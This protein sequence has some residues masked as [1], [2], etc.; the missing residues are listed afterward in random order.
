MADNRLSS[1]PVSGEP[2]E[3]APR[4]D[5]EYIL[6][7]VLQS[8]PAAV[9]LIDPALQLRAWSERWGQLA[10]LAASGD[11]A[12]AFFD[13]FAEQEQ[14][15]R[16]LQQGLDGEADQGTA[17]LLRRADGT[18]YWVDWEVQPWHTPDGDVGGAL[19]SVSDQTLRHRAEDRFRALADTVDE[20]VLLMDRSGVFQAC[21]ARAEHI[22]GR[23][24]DEIVG[25][26]FRDAKWR[27]L[28]E[29]GT[30]LS[31]ESFPFWVA[32]Y[33][34]EPVSANSTAPEQAVATIAPES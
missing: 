26:S 21:N 9:A 31:N 12:P 4:S 8:V 34:G 29:D 17:T 10:G 19:L 7:Q 27:G 1:S 22:L 2:T 23:P 24:A 13:V 6:R 16:V 32:R 15:R 3:N 33:T 30:P 20:G 5:R 28:R 18:E 11:H 14:W 25:S